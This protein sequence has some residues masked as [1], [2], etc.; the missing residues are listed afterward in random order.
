M[1]RRP[2]G[3]RDV[4]G[5]REDEPIFSCVVAQTA[6]MQM[7]VTVNWAT[8][9]RIRSALT[10]QLSLDEVTVVGSSLRMCMPLPVVSEYPPPIAFLPAGH[11]AVLVAGPL[12]L[13]VTDK[14]VTMA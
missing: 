4:G 14:E 5:N 9:P 13:I 12:L 10:D 7:T 6:V 1:S 11:V 3:C 8:L 2:P